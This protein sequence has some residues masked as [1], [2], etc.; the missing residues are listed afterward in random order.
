MI[1]IKSIEDILNRLNKLELEYSKE[2]VSN[3]GEEVPRV[4]EILSQMI[5]DDYLLPWA[6]SLGFKHIRYKS[7]MKE[8]ADK[9]TYSH[10]AI[11]RFLKYNEYFDPNIDNILYP[12]NVVDIIDSTFN[13]FLIWWNNLN[14]N[15]KVEI[16]FS[17]EKLVGKYFG[18]TCDCVLKINDK[19]WLIDF[20]TSNHMNYKYTLQLSAYRYLL[21]EIKDIDISGCCVLLLDKTNYSFKEYILDL[22]DPIH[23]Q[24]TDQC[25]ELFLLLSASYKM[26]VYTNNEYNKIF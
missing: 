22:E 10:L 9:G 6:N 25:T 1:K 17:E 16:I 14:K 4:T 2:Y 8:A 11:E 26:R 20:K 3:N 21:K 12:K 23:K 24:Y 5:H 7:Y 18:G 15:N 19:Y 13:G